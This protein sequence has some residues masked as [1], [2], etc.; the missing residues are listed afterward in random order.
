MSKPTVFQ[1]VAYGLGAAAYGVK[2]N[3][4]TYFLL[5]FYSTVV[6]LEPGLVG[7]AIFIALVFDAFSDP[8]VGYISD[9][10]RSTWG[11][12]HPFMY[13]S[14]VP[15]ALSYF[16]LWNPPDWNETQLFWYLLVLAIFHL[17]LQLAVQS[18]PEGGAPNLR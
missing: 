3:G 17:L 9:N 10:W 14:A 5:L 8:I 11:R 6:G 16:L 7:L 15:G 2:D 12:R 1:K 13:A 18:L 4:F